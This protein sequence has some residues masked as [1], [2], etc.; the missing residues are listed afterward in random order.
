ME[1]R[2]DIGR[3]VT[4]SGPTSQ[5]LSNIRNDHKKTLAEEKRSRQ[6]ISQLGK[7]KGLKNIGLKDNDIDF[8]SGL[9]FRLN[10]HKNIQLAI[11][12]GQIYSTKQI[13]NMKREGRRVGADE[14]SDQ[15]AEH[16]LDRLPDQWFSDIDTVYINQVTLAALN[17]LILVFIGNDLTAEYIFTGLEQSCLSKDGPA[18]IAIAFRGKTLYHQYQDRANRIANAI[19]ISYEYGTDIIP[20]LQMYYLLRRVLPISQDTAVVKLHT[21]TK[22]KW[23]HVVSDFIFN[24]TWDELERKLQES[25][26]RTITDPSYMHTLSIDSYFLENYKK[27]YSN[28]LDPSPNA[29]FAAGSIFYCHAGVFDKIIEFMSNNVCRC[30]FVNNMYINNVIIRDSPIHFIERLFGLL[31]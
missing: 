25:G 7:S 1:L 30:Y 13:E 21:K 28:N 10:G 17:R 27:K 19:F 29:C 3:P 5:F 8:D 31:V 15:G 6:I 20:T 12:N 11:D 26:Q 22:V 23:L 16:M 14:E 9:C 4:I 24:S 2:F 18:Y